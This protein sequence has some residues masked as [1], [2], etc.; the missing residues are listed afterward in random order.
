M[1][2]QPT[3][4]RP[5][6]VGA[7]D[8]TQAGE[9]PVRARRDRWHWVEPSVWT[10]RMLTALEEGV[11]GGRWFSL[12]DKVWSRADPGGVLATGARQQGAAGGGSRDGRE[13]RGG[14]GSDTWRS[15]SERLT[16]GAATSLAPVRR[17]L[18]PQARE[19]QAA[20]AGH[21]D[22]PRPGRAGGAAAG[23]GA[24]L[25]EG[26][27]RATATGSARARMQ[28][29]AAAG[30]RRCCESG[31]RYVVDADLQ[32]LLRH[33]SARSAAGAGEATEVADGRV[34]ASAASG[35]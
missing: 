19:R 21:P 20:T 1:R 35:S 24:D 31:H 26:L 10:E 25:R 4:Q 15:W 8:A 17:V 28:G 29:R 2:T 11:K 9:I 33:D 16:R 18:D 5:A 34:L 22:G 27:R 7:T 32:E 14:C 23:A 6:P 3:D 30:G 12:I 13:V